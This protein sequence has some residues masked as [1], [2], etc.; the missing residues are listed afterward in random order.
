MN[1][2]IAFLL[3]GSL[4]LTACA[5]SP[6]RVEQGRYVT[7]DGFGFSVGLPQDLV[8]AGWTIKADRNPAVSQTSYNF[9]FMPPEGVEGLVPVT[10]NSG[11]NG[12]RETTTETLER[13]LRLRPDLPP[14]E[15]LTDGPVVLDRWP[16]VVE[17]ETTWLYSDQASSVSQR[18]VVW[19]DL[20]MEISA[21]QAVFLNEGESQQE[22]LARL[23]ALWPPSL[24]VARRIADTLR[25]K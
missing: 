10:V 19:G 24:D 8:D 23:R 16:D 2:G 11:E 12:P 4:L 25:L 9:H 22:A 5:E 17:I 3:S 13:M 14:V 18:L 1:K 7:H 15:L 20:S 6:V 21:N